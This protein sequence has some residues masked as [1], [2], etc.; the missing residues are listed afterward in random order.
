VNKDERI[1]E[2]RT[3]LSPTNRTDRIWT[4]GAFE[5]LSIQRAPTDLLYLNHDNRRFR[6]EA[7]GAAAELGRQLDPASNP[8]DE[9]SIISLLLDRDPHV[10][11]DEILGK[12]SKDAVA[13]KSDWEKRGQEKPFWIRPDGLV[14]NGNR[15]LAMIKREQAALGSEFSPWVDVILFAEDEYDNE[16]V[17]DLESAE[18][19]TEGLKVRYSDINVLLT[20]RDAAERDEVDWADAESIERV[21]S[22]IQ[23]LVNNDPSYALVQ[24]NAIKY[25][26][27]YLDDIGDAG[28]YHRLQR[29]VERFREVGIT[30]SAV[31]TDD[32][33]REDRMLGVMFAAIQANSTNLDIRAIRQMWRTKPEEFDEL[34]G[35]IEELETEAEPEPE[36]DEPEAPDLIDDDDEEEEEEDVPAP[37]SPDYP[38][39]AVKRALD[40]AVQTVNDARKRDKRSH[41]LSAASR[42]AAI[43]A[44]DLKGHL[45]EGAEATALREAVATV[46]AWADEMRPLLE[47]T[48]AD[49][50]P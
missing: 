38:K 41:V 7:Q 13:L 11:G 29:M 48:Q 22:R 49:A 43:S 5:D 35:Y 36:E 31:A 37:T 33:S 27:L 1:A 9:A 12:P 4:K 40:N 17:F 46:V 8:H 39:Q 45:G 14:L 32:P 26:D 3:K 44:D 10:E 20:L 24:L 34:Y 6:A 16:V 42:L 19:L 15:R 30:M 25:M 18:Q 2:L 50:L 47:E 23:H 28:E 21:A